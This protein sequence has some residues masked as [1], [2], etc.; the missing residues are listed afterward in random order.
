M[1]IAQI[2]CPPYSEDLLFELDILR[3]SQKSMCYLPYLLE[4]RSQWG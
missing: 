2:S 1:N 4:D 3:E